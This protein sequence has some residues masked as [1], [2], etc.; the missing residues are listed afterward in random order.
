MSTICGRTVK[1]LITTF[2]CTNTF[3]LFRRGVIY[4]AEDGRST[5]PPPHMVASERQLLFKVAQAAYHTN[6]AHLMNKFLMKLIVQ[7]ECGSR[8]QQR[9]ITLE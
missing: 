1:E 4:E 5:R 9:K 2:Y 7:Y 6:H 3:L 8:D